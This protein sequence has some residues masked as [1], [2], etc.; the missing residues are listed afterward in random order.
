MAGLIERY[1][2][3][4]C[5][6]TC[7]RAAPRRRLRR[8]A[9]LDRRASSSR[10]RRRATIYGRLIELFGGHTPTPRELLEPRPRGDARRR[11]CRAPKVAY[12][13]DL[14]EHVEDGELRAGAAR[15][16]A[17]R[18]G[19]RPA[20]GDQGARPVDGRHVPDLP[21]RPP[22]RAAGGRPGRPARGPDPVHGLDEL[23]DAGRARADRRALAPAPLAG[24][25]LPLAL[26]GQRARPECRAPLRRRLPQLGSSSATRKEEPQ[27]HEA[28][29]FGFE[30]SKPGAHE[31]LGV[32][33]GRAVDVAGG[34]PGRRAR[35]CRA[36]SKTWSSS[37]CSS[38]ASAYWKPE[39]PPP[40]T[41]TR[42][43][44]VARRRSGP[45]MKA[46][47]FS[48]AM[49]VSM[50]IAPIVSAIA[51]GTLKIAMPP[52]TSSSSAS[53]TRCPAPRSRWRT[54]PAAATIS[55][56]R[57]SPT[58]SRACPASSSTSWSTTCSATRSAAPI[59]ALSIKTSTPGEDQR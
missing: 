59:H 6:A 33:D 21:P 49:S 26:A 55:A 20:D 56:P 5:G 12:L 8:A 7:A 32:V 14:A 15:R 29:T 37:C 16:A 38:S 11:A 45:S 51:L 31:A 10:P 52:P 57:S 23:P 46:R 24:V 27:P 43:P 40:R 19:G 3:A 47:T 54:S 58:A 9:A 22:R 13:R 4:R 35:G 34:S 42:R 53:S 36:A 39:Q 48:A 50:T 30:T 41:P 18:G 17:R 1:G 2:D 25:P 44:D 28:T